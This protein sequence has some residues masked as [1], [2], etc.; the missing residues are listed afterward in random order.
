MADQTP[1]DKAA[2]LLQRFPIT[3]MARAIHRKGTARDTFLRSYVAAGFHGYSYQPFREMAPEICGVARALDPSEPMDMP[4]I[5]E[6]ISRRVSKLK[7]RPVANTRMNLSAARAL[8][9]AVRPI[10][11]PCFRYD[12]GPTALRLDLDRR[13]NLG[14]GFYFVDDDRPVFRFMQPRQGIVPEEITIML[15][16]L[17]HGLVRGPYAAARV[18]VHELSQ[19]DPKG[20]R[21]SD[22]LGLADGEMLGRQAIEQDAQEVY[23]ILIR[24]ANGD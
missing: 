19:P 11:L 9:R 17:H 13:V 23:E 20:E 22:I 10:S 4:A 3:D 2:K 5:E 8:A 18:E 16:I 14:V 21:R 7:T 12:D 6:E 15:S 1:S 24:I